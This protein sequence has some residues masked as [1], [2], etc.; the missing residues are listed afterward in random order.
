MATCGRW[1]R[2]QFWQPAAF[3]DHVEPALPGAGESFIELA[4]ASIHSGSSCLAAF[5]LHSISQ[6][7]PTSMLVISASPAI[8][9]TRVDPRC[10][11]LPMST[12]AG[13]KVQL[14]C[15]QPWATPQLLRCTV[16][17]DQAAAAS[18]QLV[19]LGY[20]LLAC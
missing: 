5:N 8:Q 10:I 3:S 17:A 20:V 1:L 2:Q 4:A 11:Y 7:R 19:D 6:V 14:T 12:I 15:L 13:S 18:E 16:A 9:T